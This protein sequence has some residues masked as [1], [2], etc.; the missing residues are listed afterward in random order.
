MNTTEYDPFVLNYISI[1]Y[2]KQK[3]KSLINIWQQKKKKTSERVLSI[4]VFIKEGHYVHMSGVCCCSPWF[5]DYLSLPCGGGN[6]GLHKHVRYIKF[7]QM[8]K[9]HNVPVHFL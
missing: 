3:Y 7:A 5:I 1:L 6:P 2:C 4:K 9:F 8:F